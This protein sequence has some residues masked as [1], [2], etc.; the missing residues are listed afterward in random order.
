MV[1]DA[2]GDADVLGHRAVHAIAEAFARGIE[3]VKPAL[4]HRV[5]LGDNGGGLG[6]D[7]VTFLPAFDLFADLNDVPA[8][9]VAEH[10]GVVHRPAVVSGPLV[11][12]GAADANVGDFE[13]DVSGADVRPLDFTDFDGPFFGGVIDD[14]G[15]LHGGETVEVDRIA[16]ILEDSQ[17]LFWSR[18]TPRQRVGEMRRWAEG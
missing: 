17:D 7:A 9:L 8:E 16:G 5:V 13:K 11:K 6:D 3:V 15:G 14:S 12:I 1:E 10:D 4:G 2:A 18:G